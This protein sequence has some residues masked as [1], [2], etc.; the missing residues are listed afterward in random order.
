MA[1][2]GHHQEPTMTTPEAIAELMN[3]YNAARA[4]WVAKL[5]DLFDEADFH[6]WFTRQVTGKK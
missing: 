2:D 6:A 3:Q 1:K 4:A 5:G